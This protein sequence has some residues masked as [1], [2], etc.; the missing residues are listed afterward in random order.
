MTHTDP[1]IAEI[2]LIRQAIS[3]EFNHDPKQMY[4]Y[5]QRIEQELKDTGKY[6]F[7]ETEKG[8]IIL[9]EPL[10]AITVSKG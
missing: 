5:Y 8:R 10:P 1:L 6:T 9:A 3:A 7:V 2:R 4:T